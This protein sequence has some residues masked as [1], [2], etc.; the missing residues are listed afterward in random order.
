MIEE[1]AKYRGLVDR[2]SAADVAERAFGGATALLAVSQEIATYL[3]R[4]PAARGRVH[5][6]P[7]GVN[8]CRFRQGL[9]PSLPGPPQSCTVGF[10]GT[11]KPWHGLSVLME[12]F[13]LFHQHRKN[14]RLLI[15]G[16]GP[17][18]AHLEADLVDRGLQDAVHL[19]G[20]IA[21]AKVPGLLAS[22][23]VAVAPYPALDPFYFS[24][25]KV[26]EYM[27][28]GLPVLAS[29]VG[30]LE[31]LILHEV[32]GILCPPGNATALAAALERLQGDPGLCIRLGR[33]ARATVF[34]DHTWDGVV[35][36]IIHLA[37]LD[38]ISAPKYLG[39]GK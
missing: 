31:M 8:P 30:Q 17:E 13:A 7:N 15:V 16:E 39:V 38:R 29:R 37:G 4:Y 28:A 14:T 24:P 23:D 25:L 11:L 22:M 9:P 34:R 6:V 36:R 27:A 1:Q 35:R 3:N 32:N 10:V 21:P 33:E 26:Y 2:A 18:R 12:A 5:V 20:A 19:V